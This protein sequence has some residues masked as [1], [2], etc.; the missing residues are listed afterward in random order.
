MTRY[1]EVV[2]VGR[3]VKGAVGELRSRNRVEIEPADENKT[4]VKM[5]AEVA[6]GGMLGSVGTKVMQ[7]KAKHVAKEFAAT[8]SEQIQL[9]R[10]RQER[11]GPGL[12]PAERLH[13]LLEARL[14]VPAREP[15]VGSSYDGA[16]GCAAVRPGHP[17]R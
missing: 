9:F 15:P 16:C 11:S 2:S 7:I 3:S 13:D 17:R 12:A 14:A 8:L 1:V 6:L 4:T 10:A 5:A